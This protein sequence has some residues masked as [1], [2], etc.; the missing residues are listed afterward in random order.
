MKNKPSKAATAYRWVFVLI[1]ATMA[2]DMLDGMP[3]GTPSAPMPVIVP[4]I[5]QLNIELPPVDDIIVVPEPVSEPVAV[6]AAPT[7][8]VAMS[9]LDLLPPPPPP[10]P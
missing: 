1:V 8:D 2:I 4:D 3:G 9:G 10:F 5:P 7:A 6:P